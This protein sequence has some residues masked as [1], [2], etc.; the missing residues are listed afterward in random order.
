MKTLEH[1]SHGVVHANAGVSETSHGADDGNHRLGRRETKSK[2]HPVLQ[3]PA[4]C[5]ARTV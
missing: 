5:F 2:A 1:R 4:L 3:S